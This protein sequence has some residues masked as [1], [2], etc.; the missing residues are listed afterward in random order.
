MFSKRYQALP[1]RGIG[2]WQEIG[3]V[4]FKFLIILN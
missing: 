1:A 2:L 3:E 4:S